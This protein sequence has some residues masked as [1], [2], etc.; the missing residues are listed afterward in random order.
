MSTGTVTS[1]FSAHP[2][3]YEPDDQWKADLKETLSIAFKDML[4]QAKQKLEADL[5]SLG[6]DIDPVQKKK[7]IDEYQA[8]ERQ[9]KSFATQSFKVEVEKEREQ[10]RWAAGL[11]IRTAWKEDL[12]SE[13]QAIMSG[14][15]RQR[16]GSAGAESNVYPKGRD[17]E[18]TVPDRLPDSHQH[19]T[20]TMPTPTP[21]STA[22]RPSP[23]PIPTPQRRSSTSGTPGNSV[24]KNPEVWIPPKSAAEDKPMPLGRRTSQTSIGRSPSQTFKPSAPIPEAQ[25]PPS[26]TD[27]RPS[28]S[29]VSKTSPLPE[30]P[31]HATT[32]YDHSESRTSPPQTSR[33]SVS[34][35]ENRKHP[36]RDSR[37]PPSYTRPSGSI[38]ENNR[39]PIP[40]HVDSKDQSAATRHSVPIHVHE[41]A[42]RER[43]RID[44][45]DQSWASH[46]RA[47]GKEEV[48]NDQPP[49]PAPRSVSVNQD[50]GR[51]PTPPMATKP[52]YP[53]SLL[54]TSRPS[55]ITSSR[56]PATLRQASS[57]SDG[58]SLYRQPSLDAS[59][60]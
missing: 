36:D 57:S 30:I 41:N 37:L 26:N 27:S 7:L 45:A 31:K 14:I 32:E 10:R 40:E 3:L 34:T 20:I 54:T 42:E 56:P 38:P 55:S 13:Q 52:A 51:P 46:N 22:T 59:S 23:I 25:K 6:D 47:K 2:D 5:Q 17:R 29:Y 49:S 1:E 24:S 53:P 18:S 4:L 16:T 35:L 21:T 19:T 43:A 58:Y 48:E 50:V 44:E 28:S 11:E 33:S 39:R 8:S 12:E 60:S 15:R 9:I